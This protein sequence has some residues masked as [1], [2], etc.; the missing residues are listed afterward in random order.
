MAKV[1]GLGGFFFHCKDVAATREWYVRVLG[2]SLGD[3]GGS[4]FSY[5]P[6]V[7]KYGRGAMT[8]WAPFEAGGDYF[9]PSSENHMINFI[10]DDLDGLLERVSAEGVDQTQPREDH[11]YGSFAWVLD[12]DGRKIELWEPK[13]EPPASD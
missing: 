1:I 11:P 9:K 4:M 2:V 5:A 13:G 8:I 3:D 6:A 10:V 12:P 7:E